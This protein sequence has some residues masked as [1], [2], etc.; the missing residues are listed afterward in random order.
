MCL[1]ITVTE[2]QSCPG[3]NL[4]FYWLRKKIINGIVN[5]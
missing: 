1:A 2:P 4:P 5:F 3:C